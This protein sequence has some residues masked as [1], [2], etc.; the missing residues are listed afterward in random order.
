MNV[1]HGQLLGN[2]VQWT[3]NEQQPAKV[4]GPGLL[5]V[6]VWR[7]QQ[8][9]TVHLVNLTNPM[10]MKGPFRELIPVGQQEVQV[11]LPKDVSATGVQLLVSGLRPDYEAE[12]GTLSLT[13]PSVLDHEVIAIDLTI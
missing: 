9:M 8:S 10:M 13:V 11:R 6:T 3:L 7:Q 12:N 2:I 5:D 4:T 1:D